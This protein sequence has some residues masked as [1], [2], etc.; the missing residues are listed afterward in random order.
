M[1]RRN[2]DAIS[3]RND[4]YLLSNLVL[5]RIPPTEE[6]MVQLQRARELRLTDAYA[7]SII[8]SAAKATA[9]GLLQHIVT[10]IPVICATL[11]ATRTLGNNTSWVPSLIFVDEAS[12][13]TE[14]QVAVVISH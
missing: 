14:A 9:T 8:E 12:R 2:A 10:A 13:M 4:P 7:F 11:V 5:S 1:V 6:R 3:A